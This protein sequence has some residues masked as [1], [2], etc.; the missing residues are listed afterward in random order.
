MSWL[1]RSIANTLKLDET[2]DHEGSAVVSN[3]NERDAEHEKQQNQN[4]D[5]SSSSPTSTPR[6]VKDD[7]SELTKTLTRQFWGVASFLA[8]PPQSEPYKPLQDS[9]STTPRGKSISR[10]DQDQLDSQAIGITGIRND[11]AEIGG[12]FRSGISIL[13]NNIAVSE[14]TKMASDFLQL[15]SDNEE[16]EGEGNNALSSGG[17]VGVTNEVVSFARD[18]AMH[19]ETWLDFPLPLPESDDDDDFDLSDAQQEHALAVE[20]LAPRLAA[21]RI[22]LCPG[23]M[24]ESC[25]WKI[26]FVLLHP[27]LDKKD[28]ELLSTPQI[29]KARALL[30]QGLKNRS[31]A[32]Q[33]DW[34]G[35]G[36]IDVQDNSNHQPEEPLLVP[37]KT[38]YDN[39][40][41]TS[42]TESVTS[43]AAI[44]H[45]IEKH[46]VMSAEI[47]IVDKPVIEEKYVDQT[48][49][50]S[51]LFDSSNV[52]VEKDEDDADDWLK[53]ESSGAG[54]GGATIP[55]END[56]D[57]SFSDL[58]EDDMDVPASF[59]KTSHSPDK[60]ARDWVQLRKSSSDLSNS[61]QSGAIE[62]AG[63]KKVIP[64]NPDSKESSDWL[65]VDDID[66]A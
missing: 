10:S 21:L 45:E 4:L 32:K 35:E 66:V 61:T 65:D 34:S 51:I 63:S 33:E 30:S 62:T 48:K 37:I 20:Q 25:F 28:A 18:I 43:T 53:E 60:D 15:G 3:L 50:Q 22:E 17:A 12:K 58:E 64:R 38:E 7:I 6:G 44:E 16:E 56:E 36:T 2:D 42:F 13:S 47:A 46:P 27:R 9:E 23:Y 29:V 31:K 59:K 39:V 40:P 54:A 26:Y 24:S 55:I 1:A 14:F 5:P 41:K 8:P 11:F 57:V 52:L 49:D 19:P